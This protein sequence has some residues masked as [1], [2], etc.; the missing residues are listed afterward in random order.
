MSVF[1]AD[2]MQDLPEWLEIASEE[3]AAPAKERI[4]LE[5]EAH[6]AE[7]AAAH[8]AEGLSESDARK[9]ALADL[10]DA[11]EAARRFSK[12]HLTERDAKTVERALKQLAS[13]WQLLYCLL[14]FLSASWF[15]PFYY[16]GGPDHLSFVVPFAI[17][18]F[19][20]IVRTA[21]F[22]MARRK[23]AKL[24]TGIFFLTLAGTFYAWGL[25]LFF[26]MFGLSYDFSP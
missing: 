7:A 9:A 11:K 4:R 18:F 15:V 2:Q 8:L 12:Q 26:Y 14:L 20:I 25:S 10:G 1:Q 23:S 19:A 5:I 6:Y 24:N 13:R 16:R 22:I 21:C 3:L 17:G